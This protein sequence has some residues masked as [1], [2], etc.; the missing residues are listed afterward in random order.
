MSNP[1][2][3]T[4]G[5]QEGTP[6]FAKKSPKATT[7]STQMKQVRIVDLVNHIR[8]SPPR[9]NSRSLLHRGQRL[10]SQL[11]LLHSY[12]KNAENLKHFHFFFFEDYIDLSHRHNIYL[13]SLLR[14]LAIRSTTSASTFLSDTQ[15]MNIVSQEVYNMSHIRTIYNKYKNFLLTHTSLQKS[16]IQT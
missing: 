10:A 3:I 7:N 2:I 9:C 6:H 11:T 5:F 15:S 14:L 1:R 13:G 8:G 4:I 12:D 16:L